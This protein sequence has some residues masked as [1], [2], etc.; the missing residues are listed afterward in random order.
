MEEE[1][2]QPLLRETPTKRWHWL[3]NIHSVLSLTLA[4]A[5]GALVCLNC[6]Q[7]R[8]LDKDR[9]RIS[10]AVQEARSWEREAEETREALEQERE[11]VISRGE[12][13]AALQKEADFWAE[14]A[15]L[16]TESGEKYH[17]YGCSTLREDTEVSV[18]D[19]EAAAALGYTPCSLCRG[20]LNPASDLLP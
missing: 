8:E 13:L 20:A 4:L 19:G 5:V 15:V 3:V 18:L 16:V 6:A 12:E 17:A 7:S 2:K 1:E 10:E 11:R 9:G 14:R